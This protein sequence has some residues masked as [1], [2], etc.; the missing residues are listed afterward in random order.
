LCRSSL[1]VCRRQNLI[2]DVEGHSLSASIPCRTLPGIHAHARRQRKSLP[3]FYNIII[4]LLQYLYDGRLH[5]SYTHRSRI[6]RLFPCLQQYKRVTKYADI[7]MPWRR[8][9]KADGSVQGVDERQLVEA[10]QAVTTRAARTRPA[11]RAGGGA[12]RACREGSV[13]WDSR[14]AVTPHD[15][16][17]C[18]GHAGMPWRTTEARGV[19]TGHTLPKEGHP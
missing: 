9:R 1:V 14:R 19:V 7:R 11:R 3:F 12:R 6:G 2:T 5:V 10:A 18:E 13:W 4:T 8:V 17:A 15:P 16:R